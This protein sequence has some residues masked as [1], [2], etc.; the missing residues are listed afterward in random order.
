MKDLD[1][2]I[3]LTTV[4]IF[5]ALLVVSGIAILSQAIDFALSAS[6]YSNQIY[7]E[8]R[9]ISCLEEAIY[10]FDRNNSLPSVSIDYGSG[11]SCEAVFNVISPDDE[12]VIN[13][14]S[15][16]RNTE[17]STSKNWNFASNPPVEN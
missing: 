3:A 4:L 16:Y 13:I 15:S 12:V 14:T 7:A 1:G 10:Q 17:Y 9:A 6:S 8:N 2:N 5:S 11:D